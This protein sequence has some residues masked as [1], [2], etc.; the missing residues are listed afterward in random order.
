MKIKIKSSLKNY[1]IIIKNNS[2]NQIDE[3]INIKK[4]YVIITENGLPDIYLKSL[5]EQINH[6]S[7]IIFKQGESSKN[8][9]TYQE[10]IQ[11]LSDLSITKTDCLI[12][13]GGG[14]VTDMTGFVASTYLRGIDYIQIPTTLL[15]QVDASVGGKTG[16]NHLG[17]KN[18]LGSFY[19]PILVII[20]PQT[21]NT[22]SNRQFNN[23]I[24]EI[25]KYGLIAS[26]E[27]LDILMNKSVI[28]NIEHVIYLSLK[29]KKQFIEND[30]F[31]LHE[32]HIL[33]FGHT[34]GHAYESYYKY[35]K[36]LHGEAIALGMIEMI[37]NEQLK[38][39]VIKLLED[40]HLPTSDSLNKKEL[41]NYILKDKKRIDQ[42]IK[43]IILEDIEKPIIKT[44]NLEDWLKTIS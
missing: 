28:Q 14:V 35:Q 30:E 27:L 7:V 12:A 16:I 20:D 23:G 41:I 44:I 5:Q 8:I 10:I 19:P 33:N 6:L 2:L 13:L 38:T 42:E 36:Y 22:L 15:S 11:K 17:I 32:R 9:L 25:I 21:L 1:D 4:H 40:Y 31:D 34:F 3:Y 18:V 26:Q 37:E 24:A 43:I 39:E 29:I